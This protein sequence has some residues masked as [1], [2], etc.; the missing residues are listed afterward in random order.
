MEGNPIFEH[1][2]SSKLNLFF[3]SSVYSGQKKDKR[4]DKIFQT[5]MLFIQLLLKSVSWNL[6]SKL[7]IYP[8]IVW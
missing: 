6:L 5:A 1:P 2:H 4:K 7:F 3:L 8:D